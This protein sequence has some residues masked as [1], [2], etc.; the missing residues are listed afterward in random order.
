M[1]E[2]QL[3]DTSAW[4]EYFRKDGDAAIRR[5]VIEAIRAKKAAWCELVRLE[6]MQGNAKQ[7]K[8]TDLITEALPCLHIDQ[9]CWKEA[10]QLAARASEKGTP[11]PNTDILIQACANRHEASLVHRDK[12]FRTLSE[13]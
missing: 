6:L 3:I 11:L 8:Q 12:H 13:L 7:R 10:Y 5:S 1:A 9:R 4:I 2:L